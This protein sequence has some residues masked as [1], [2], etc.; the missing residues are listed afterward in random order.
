MYIANIIALE[1]G[2]G[3]GQGEF[4][5]QSEAVLHLSLLMDGLDSNGDPE[6]CGLS[7]DQWDDRIKQA[8]EFLAKY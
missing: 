5:N 1:L 4:S 6:R 7:C 2:L 3:D 8:R